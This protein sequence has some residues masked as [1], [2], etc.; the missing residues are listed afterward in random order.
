MLAHLHSPN[1]PTEYSGGQADSII[2]A[3][4][5]T[6]RWIYRGVLYYLPGRNQNAPNKRSQYVRQG[7]DKQD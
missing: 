7:S 3:M 4:N 6:P 1:Q 5:K 2:T